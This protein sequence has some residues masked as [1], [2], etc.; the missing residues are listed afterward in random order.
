MLEPIVCDRRI[1]EQAAWYE[2]DG[3][4]SIFEYTQC[5]E[6]IKIWEGKTAALFGKSSIHNSCSAEEKGTKQ[7][8]RLH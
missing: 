1:M 4:I 6:N 8:S 7:L 2:N 3:D 5:D